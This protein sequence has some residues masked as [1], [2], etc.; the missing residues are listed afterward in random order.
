MKK[1]LL[2]L[3]FINVFISCNSSST[4]EKKYKYF[5]DNRWLNSDV[6]EFEFIINEE[7]M[8]N[9]N[10]K[11]SHVFDYQFNSVPLVISFEKPNS[12]IEKYDL[13]L[14]LK[15]NSG[16]DIADCAG[17]YCDLDFKLYQKTLL[18]KGTYKINVANKFKAGF[19]PNILAIGLKVEK[20]K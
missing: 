15:D 3:I 11:F 5:E 16:K 19:L 8:Y 7:S 14:T 4:F 17:D 20:A 2:F 9:I 12:K 10:L 6:K 13:G 1:I 18:T